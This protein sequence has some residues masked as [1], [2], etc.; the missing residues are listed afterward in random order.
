VRVSPW[1]LRFLRIILGIITLV[2]TSVRRITRALLWKIRKSE[3]TASILAPP[4][5]KLAQEAVQGTNTFTRNLAKPRK[6]VIGALLHYLRWPSQWKAGELVIGYNNLSEIHFEWTEEKKAVAQRL[7]YA[8]DDVIENI[9]LTEYQDTLELPM[10][11]AA[12]PLP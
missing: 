3:Q 12:P 4:A 7:W 6:K 11:D 10:P 8:G 2:E 9:L 1:I 5:G